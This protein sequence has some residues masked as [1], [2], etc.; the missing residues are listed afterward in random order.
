MK[1]K[2]LLLFFISLICV[3]FVVSSSVLIVHSQR[4][5][6][7]RKELAEFYED[8]EIAEIISQI[9][10]CDSI[11]DVDLD[12]FSALI[13][14]VSDLSPEAFSM[15]L[16]EQSDYPFLQNAFLQIAEKNRIPIQE[17]TIDTLL[18]GNTS[19]EIK[20]ELIFYCSMFGETYA[21]KIEAMFYDPDVAHWALRTM[22]NI[23]PEKT[24]ETVDSI[25]ENYNGV[26]NK[27]VQGALRVKVYAL[28][29]SSTQQEREDYIN[30]CHK[31]IEDQKDNSDISNLILMYISSL[32]SYE[33]LSY[34]LDN[35]AFSDQNVLLSTE[36]KNAILEILSKDPEVKE[37]ELAI[38]ALSYCPNPEFYDVLCDHINRNAAFYDN[39]PELYSMVQDILLEIEK[40]MNEQSSFDNNK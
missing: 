8:V 14:K 33:S 38:K 25:L 32:D 40:E 39:N 10:Q 30:L 11:E 37:I 19:T 13:D 28:Q 35:D 29:N 7:L 6:L 4:N 23:N 2:K 16:V 15:L 1:S 27:T 18:F 3:V 36:Q 22:Y 20:T 24:V 12:A 31:I 34:L 9:K 21:D 5:K 17:N 26:F